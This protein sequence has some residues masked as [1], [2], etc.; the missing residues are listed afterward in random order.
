[1]IDDLVTLGVDE[2]YRMFT[3]RAERRLSLRQDNVFYRLADM[4]YNLGLITQNFYDEIKQEQML[5]SQVV[6]DIRSGKNN[7]D[8]LKLLGRDETNIERI[9]EITHHQLNNRAALA[10]WAEV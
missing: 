10:V 5:V 4:S 6:R 8:L 1:M 9:H 7:E 2:P 3:S